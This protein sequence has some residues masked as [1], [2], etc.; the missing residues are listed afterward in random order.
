MLDY[1]TTRGRFLDRMVDLEELL[2]VVLTAYLTRSSVKGDLRT[3]RLRSPQAGLLFHE[4]LPKVR[5]RE[6]VQL[7][8]T[9]LRQQTVDGDFDDLPK[10][11]DV[12]VDIRNAFAHRRVMEIARSVEWVGTEF[13]VVDDD[14]TVAFLKRNVN[15]RS[16][17]ID[18][19]EV[20]GETERR[21]EELFHTLDEAEALVLRFGEALVRR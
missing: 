20:R 2:D 10:R 19:H 21:V 6:K 18:F 7:V 4:L 13:A 1:G 5:L 11:L 9:I 12:L 14:P 15:L 3:T 17:S 8:R 16:V